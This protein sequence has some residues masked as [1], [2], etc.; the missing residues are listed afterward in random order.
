MRFVKFALLP[1]A[2]SALTL[3]PT[4][5]AQACTRGCEGYVSRTCL[6]DEACGPRRLDTRFG[7]D[8]W[9]LRAPHTY[10]RTVSRFDVEAVRLFQ[11]MP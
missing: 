8:T 7:A 1:A 4:A 2:L 10:L 9:H 3:L 6:W 5:P 11:R